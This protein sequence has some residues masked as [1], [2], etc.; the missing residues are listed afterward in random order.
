MLSLQNLHTSYGHIRILKGVSLDIYEGEL[1]TLL[2]RNG[3]GKS[4]T[5]KSIMGIVPPR[6]GTVTF[7]KE[8][9]VGKR[10]YEVASLGIAYVPEERGVFPSLTVRENLEIASHRG[11]DFKKNLE[12]IYS[13]F[14]M[15]KDR[16]Q[17]KGSQ[18]SG[19]EQQMLAIARALCMEPRLI[20]LDEPTEGL[21]PFLVSRIAEILKKIKKS[22]IT[23]LLI[24][25]NA[26]FTTELANRHY[27]ISHGE[28]VYEA[29]NEHF[30]QDKEAQHKYLGI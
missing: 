5:L 29:S 14:P 22:G 6:K 23:V 13:F 28:I 16:A 11:K 30:I 8:N 18:L 15:L 19:G 20:L 24:E 12:T 26:R 9:I 21:A 1:V 25:Q 7:R 2:G 3:A 17:H 10:A 4:T 27:I